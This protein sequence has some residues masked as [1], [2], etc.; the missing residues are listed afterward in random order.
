MKS[1]SYSIHVPKDQLRKLEDP[2]GNHHDTV[3]AMVSV[4]DLPNL[5]TKINPRAQDLTSRVAK[6]ISSGLTENSDN[7]FLLNRGLTVVAKDV[8]YDAKTETLNLSMPD[9]PHYGVLDGGHSM[10]VIQETITA[11]GEDKSY[12]DAFV[13]LE[14]LTNLNDDLIASIS[15]ARNTSIQV[16]A[17]S[18]ANLQHHFD[19]IKDALSAEKFA[20]KI[21]YRENEDWDVYPIN[22]ME[23]LALSTAFH[24]SFA[25]SENENP[26]V[27][28]YSSRARCLEMFQNPEMEAGYL[29]IKP[30][31]GDILKLYDFIHLKFPQL[32]KES[33][34][35]S[36]L[37]D[38][39]VERKGVRMGNLVEIKQIKDGFPL[40]YID[41]KATYKVPDGFLLPILASLR[42][43]LDYKPKTTSWKTNPFEFFTNY[44]KKLVAATLETSRDLGR[45]PNAVGKSKPHWTNLQ[46]KVELIVAKKL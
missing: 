15:Q 3:Y 5:P 7:F 28:S 22:I 31:L 1:K 43:L 23:I 11:N 13:K 12:L 21:A 37:A 41:E 17:Y 19:W 42:P 29:S 33:G 2:S 38:S 8:V 18:L 27:M 25:Q 16:K 34:G 44:G 4:K 20:G 39:T 45:S 6:E 30:V 32:Y 14:I 26:P 40:F 35:I 46:N 36:S 9:S 24:P 10:R